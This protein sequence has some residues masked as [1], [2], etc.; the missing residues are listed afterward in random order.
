[1][2]DDPSLAE[3]GFAAN[4]FQ[5]LRADLEKRFHGRGSNVL[6]RAILEAAAE[7]F[8]TTPDGEGR[9]RS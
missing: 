1:M 3:L 4:L 6:V 2:S 5:I 7:I 9:R 8:E